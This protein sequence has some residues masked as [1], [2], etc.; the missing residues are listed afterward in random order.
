MQNNNYNFFCAHLIGGIK[1]G[2]Q[3]AKTWDYEIENSSNGID[4]YALTS[5]F[6]P[7]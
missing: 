1:F 7:A 6:W 3:I 2:E 5:L 4:L